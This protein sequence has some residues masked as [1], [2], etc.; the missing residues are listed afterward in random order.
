MH[1]EGIAKGSETRLRSRQQTNALSCRPLALP[2]DTPIRRISPPRPQ[3]APAVV[4]KGDPAGW[5]DDEEFSLEM[6]STSDKDGGGIVQKGGGDAKGRHMSFR[7]IAEAAEEFAAVQL[8]NQ[9]RVYSSLLGGL[10]A[11][12][13]QSVSALPAGYGKTE[14][15]LRKQW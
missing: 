12:E 1:G 11:S 3:L 15:L 10:V 9:A 2:S 5:D 13:A 7:D 8:S 4:A 6:P 14:R